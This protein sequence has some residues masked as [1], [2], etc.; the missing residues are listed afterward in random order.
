V[1]PHRRLPPHRNRHPV[2]RSRNQTGSRTGGGAAA[3]AAACPGGQAGPGGRRAKVKK[4]APAKLAP[5]EEGE[6]QHGP[7]ERLDALPGIGP[8]KAQ[9]IIDGRPYAKPED[10]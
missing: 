8:V 6:H 1:V 7:E 2:A 10:I 4:V 9:A 3:P 5:G